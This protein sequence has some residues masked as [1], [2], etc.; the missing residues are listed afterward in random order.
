MVAVNVRAV[1]AD[2]DGNGLRNI[3]EYV[4]HTDLNTKTSGLPIMQTRTSFG[5]EVTWIQGA[6]LNHGQTTVEHSADMR[7]STADCVS[8]NDRDPVD[9]VQTFAA[10]ITGEAGLADERYMGIHWSLGR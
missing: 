9:D 3:K 1:T 8:L 7:V 4:R 5:P 6:E 10:R 2:P